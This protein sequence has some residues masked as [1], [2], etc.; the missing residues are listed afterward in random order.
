[1][2]GIP[3]VPLTTAATADNL[4][5]QLLAHTPDTVR[6]PVRM[7]LMPKPKTITTEANN[8]PSSV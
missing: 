8:L 1:M 4:S 5:R 7:V 6:I 2:K 3:A